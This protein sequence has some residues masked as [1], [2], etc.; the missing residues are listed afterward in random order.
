MP[1][2]IAIFASGNGTNAE[3]ITKYFAGSELARVTL[4]LTN[5]RDA[6]VVKRMQQAGVDTYYVPAEQWKNEPERIAD[7]LESE[8]VDLVVLAGFMRKV[9]DPIVE[10]YRGR[11]LNIHPSLLPAYGG[12]GMYGHHVH[13]AVIAAG[14]KQSGVTVHQV[15]EEMDKGAIVA[16]QSVDITTSDTPETLEARIREVEYSLYPQAIEKVLEGMS[17]GGDAAEAESAPASVAT[18]WA[19]ALGVNYDE[20]QAKRR[21][22]EAEAMRM[23]QQPPAYRPAEGYD[24]ANTHFSAVQP[25]QYAAA[26]DAGSQPVMPSSYLLWSVL[27]IVFCCSVL[28]IVATV[29]SCQVS[30]RFYNGDYEGAERA[31]RRAQAWIIASFCVGVIQTTVFTPLY[32][33][34]GT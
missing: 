31:S 27:C 14:E 12:K 30:S 17:A 24:A 15:S 4:V 18:Q 9:A 11:M 20:Q 33:L 1:Y 3:V 29:F 25:P 34:M 8:G 21:A 2:K 22:E 10:R 26:P 13:E 28:G 16:Q 19:G 5:V 32:F 7:F 23:E 6:G